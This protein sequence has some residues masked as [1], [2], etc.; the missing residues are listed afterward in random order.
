MFLLLDPIAQNLSLSNLT[1]TVIFGN[2]SVCTVNNKC[3]FKEFA[4]AEPQSHQVNVII[5][6]EAKT[7]FTLYCNILIFSCLFN[8]LSYGNGQKF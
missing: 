5:L 1:Q 6:F 2:E 4:N 7:L 8:S 3:D